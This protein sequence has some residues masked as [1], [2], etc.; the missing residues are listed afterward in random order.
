MTTHPEIP[1]GTPNAEG[2]PAALNDVRR[3]VSELTQTLWAARRPTELM[4]TLAEAESLKST[5]DALILDVVTELEATN[6]VKPLGWASTQDF[7]T[8]VAGGHRGAGSA[9]LKLATALR[10]PLFAPV[11][12]AMAEGWL[13]T[14]K[15]QVVRRVVDD[16]PGDPD[17]RDQAVQAMLDA[18]KALD[19]TGLAKAGKHLV[20]RVDPTGQARRQEAALDREERGAHLG[21]EFWIRFDGAGGFR[22]GGRGSAE[23][24]LSLQTALLTLSRPTP[25]NG[26]TCDPASCDQPGCGHDGRDPRDHGARSFDAL[27]ELCDRAAAVKLLPDCHG[28]TPRVSVTID[29]EDLK[30]QTGHATSDTGE[31]VSAR[32]VRRLA[33]DAEVIPVILGPKSE[34]LDVG[35]RQ[36]LVT[37]AIWRALVIRDQHCR[38]PNCTRPP[39]MTHAHHLVHWADGGPTNL[40]NMILLCGHHHRLVHAGPWT[41]RA[42]GPNTYE[43]DPPP[44]IRRMTTGGRQPPDD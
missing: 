33:C 30:D 34:V 19:A 15:A 13:S 11:G 5:V 23:D 27:I 35:R 31:A 41:I 44:G 38:F 20:E 28:T 17:L 2:V 32:T 42:T 43:F 4:D 16:L 14:A 36:R 21:R 12:E 29:F 6:A 22:C 25:A 10:S 7:V 40:Q 3:Q 8:A 9:L 18:A 37:P 26:T 39:V 1:P 24:G